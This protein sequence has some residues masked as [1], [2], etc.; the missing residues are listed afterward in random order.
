MSRA[1]P[2]DAAAGP[3]TGLQC[4]ESGP[5]PCVTRALSG[6]AGEN[7]SRYRYWFSRMVALLSCTGLAASDRRA[8]KA[9]S[10]IALAH[11]VCVVGVPPPA[12]EVLEDAGS[13]SDSS[14]QSPT[15]STATDSDEVSGAAS[16]LAAS[17]Q[18]K[19]SSQG[20]AMS[21]TRVRAQEA[22]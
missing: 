4:F 11:P 1:G 14:P 8:C 19:L 15:G 16:P 13:D 10:H 3:L 18:K 7:L 21:D 2:A 6:E 9:A 5:C 17:S 22:I 20:A 12:Q